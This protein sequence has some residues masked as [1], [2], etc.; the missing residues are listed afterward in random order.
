[1]DKENFINRWKTTTDE[2]RV[3]LHLGSKEL[4]L[5]FEEQKK[6][7]LNW[8]KE[9]RTTLE[10]NASSASIEMLRKLE[11]L[12]VQA[13]LGKAETKEAMQEQRKQL[14]SLIGEANE[15]SIKLLGDSKKIVR[16]L[17][18]KADSKFDEWHTKFDLLRVQINLGT[19]DAS[20]GWKE[21]KE[22]L[23][24]S[25]HN[26]EAKL[27]KV[28]EDSEEGWTNFKSEISEAW[29]HVKNAFSKTE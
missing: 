17:A 28:S 23:N 12:E 1:M 22:D 21:K 25:I 13:T 27:G 7:I 15:A 9:A 26:L 14:T 16:D 29:K 2:L 6:E 10:S 8:S 20:D 5:T 11:E 18:V 4:T 24:K 3:Q 19:A